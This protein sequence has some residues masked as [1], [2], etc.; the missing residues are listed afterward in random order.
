V[1]VKKQRCQRPVRVPN[2][3]RAERNL[4]II[5]VDYYKLYYNPGE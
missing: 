5:P 4:P 1:V 3:D 2:P